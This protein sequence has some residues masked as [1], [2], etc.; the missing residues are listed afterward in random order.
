MIP[1]SKVVKI[2]VYPV[3]SCSGIS[4]QKCR[5]GNY[6]FDN[7]REWVIVRGN[8]GRFVS[9]R[10]FPKL[11][12]INP[13][14]TTEKLTLNAPGMSTISLNV[15]NMDLSRAASQIRVWSTTGTG[16]DEGDEIAKWLQD[17]LQ[18][19]GLRLKRLQKPREIEAKYNKTNSLNEISFA[20]TAPFLMVSEGSIEVKKSLKKYHLIYYDR[21][22]IL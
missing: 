11:S 5:I 10:E 20:D 14:L 12:L 1:V 6:G 2:L 22:L 18:K 19:D 21:I 7:D 8:S 15:A 4:L 3:K 13:T 16:T 17:F 9:Q